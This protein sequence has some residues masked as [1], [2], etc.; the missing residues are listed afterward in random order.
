[1]DFA[2]TLRDEHKDIVAKFDQRWHEW[3]SWMEKLEG[4]EQIK[5]MCPFE[6]TILKF[7]VGSIEPKFGVNLSI[8]YRASKTFSIGTGRKDAGNH[9]DFAL[10]P[11]FETAIN[12]IITPLQVSIKG[13]GFITGDYGGDWTEY[14]ATV[15]CRFR[16]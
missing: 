5:K 16:E 8:P 4:T 9:P 6:L 7:G 14:N 3:Q 2:H 11:K 13:D 10:Y 1:M 12:E 15:T